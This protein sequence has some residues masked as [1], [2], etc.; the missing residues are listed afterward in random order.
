M[1]TAYSEI[2]FFCIFYDILRIMLNLFQTQQY[3]LL[4]PSNTNLHGNAFYVSIYPI[5]IIKKFILIFHY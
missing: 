3:V 5:W 4:H 2:L 1:V